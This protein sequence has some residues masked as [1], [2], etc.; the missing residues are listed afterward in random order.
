MV[1]GRFFEV[2]DNWKKEDIELPE[3]STINAAGYDFR[4][5][6][7]ITVVPVWRSVISSMTIRPQKVH[8]G[9]KARMED[10]EVLKIYN[11][12]SSPIYR[13][14]LLAS[15]V[16]V[17]DSDYY[18]TGK[19]ISFDFWNFGIRPYTIYKGDRIGQGVFQKFL[20]V[21]NELPVERIRTGGNGSTDVEE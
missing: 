13:L 17:I 16:G 19:D 4:A 10:D 3:R 20:K 5:A 7:E 21:T 2:A 9:I 11:R 14:L 6:E 8:T 18:R 15:G 1:K 12:S